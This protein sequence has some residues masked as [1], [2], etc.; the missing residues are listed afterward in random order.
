MD[1]CWILTIVIS[2]SSELNVQGVKSEKAFNAVGK[3]IRHCGAVQREEL[4]GKSNYTLNALSLQKLFK[5][6][7]ICFPE[8]SLYGVR[9]L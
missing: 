7:P 8:E 4:I 5:C 2:S 3:V 9:G 6:T 1:L